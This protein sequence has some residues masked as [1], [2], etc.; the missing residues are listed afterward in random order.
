MVWRLPEGVGV[1]G[2][3]GAKGEKLGQCNNIINKIYI[4]IKKKSLFLNT[5][6]LDNHNKLR[7]QQ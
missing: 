7:N 3:R 2:W 6:A 5:N 4:K 1:V